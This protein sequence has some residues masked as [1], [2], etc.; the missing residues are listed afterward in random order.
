MANMIKKFR[1]LE[2]GLAADV[3]YDKQRKTFSGVG[4]FLFGFPAFPG[5]NIAI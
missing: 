2:A 1:M 4:M 5:A 3:Y